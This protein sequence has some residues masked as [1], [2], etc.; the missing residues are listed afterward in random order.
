MDDDQDKT[1]QGNIFEDF[2]GETHRWDAELESD[3][4]A[5]V[6]PLRRNTTAHDPQQR[7]SSTNMTQAEEGITFCLEDGTFAIKYYRHLQEVVCPPPYRVLSLFYM[8]NIYILEGY[9]LHLLLSRIRRN[10]L[11]ELYALDPE[12]HRDTEDKPL[13]L[14]ITRQ[15]YE[16]LREIIG[17]VHPPE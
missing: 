2:G 9:N 5:D 3:D 6:I 7:E 15:S 8:D 14:R 11:G 10:K 16:E 4:G 17:D 13:V 1:Q 12:Q